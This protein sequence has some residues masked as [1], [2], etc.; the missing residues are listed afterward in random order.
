MQVKDTIFYKKKTIN[1]GG[2]VINF[3]TP[4]IMAIVNITPDSFYKNSRYNEADQIKNRLEE[5]LKEGADFID[6]GAYSSR[7]GANDISVEEE[8]TRL[9]MA[10]NIFRKVNFP[11]PVSIDT[12]RAKVAEKMLSEY[13]VDIIND[14]S[15][16]EIEPEILEVISSYRVPYILMHMKGIPVNMQN[17]PEYDDVFKEVMSFFAYKI[18]YLYKKGIHDVILDPGFGFGKTLDNN[19]ELLKYLQDFKSMGCPMMVGISRKSMIFRL[20]MNKPEESLNG[21]TALHM[22]ALMKGAD[23]LRVHD[24]KEARQVISL[25]EAMH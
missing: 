18:D 3:D 1:C 8:L 12:F 17:N 10:M 4:K 9:D 25:F 5:C 24:V 14:I 20:L 22:A 11:L 6:I 15:G 16:G 2:K 19:Y 21:S 13:Q 23:I 7:P